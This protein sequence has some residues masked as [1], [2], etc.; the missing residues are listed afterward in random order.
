M[1][2]RTLCS[3]LLGVLLALPLF[4]VP[5]SFATEYCIPTDR[6]VVRAAKWVFV[7]EVTSSKRSSTRCKVVEQMKL[8]SLQLLKGSKREF[9]DVNYT[10]RWANQG[11]Y[12]DHSCGPTSWAFDPRPSAVGLYKGNRVIAM[13]YPAKDDPGGA[14]KAVWVYATLDLS[15]LR[16]VKRWVRWGRRPVPGPCD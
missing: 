7:A 11:R 3:S 5:S 1:R 9:A 8:R 6:D 14:R 16:S 12:D 10:Q 4:W 15:Q 2:V 13:V